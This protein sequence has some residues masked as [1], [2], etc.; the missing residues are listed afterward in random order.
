MTSEPT[1]E[2]RSPRRH[3]GPRAALRFEGEEQWVVPARP[4]P[5]APAAEDTEPPAQ[6][7]DGAPG[8]AKGKDKGEKG[9][10]RDKGGKHQRRRKADKK[11]AKESASSP[12][13]EPVDDARTVVVHLPPEFRRA[14]ERAAGEHGLSPEKLAAFVLVEWLDR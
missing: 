11:R 8:R 12:E 13:A 1:A 3:P 10:K 14:L 4:L 7:A 5:V 6:E 9:G 2:P